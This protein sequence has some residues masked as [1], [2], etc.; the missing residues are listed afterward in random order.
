MTENKRLITFI[1]PAYNEENNIRRF[2]EETN[3]TLRGLNNYTCD[4]IFIDDVL[5]ALKKA[6]NVPKIEGEIFNI[7]SGIGYSLN[8]IVNKIEIAMCKKIK[9][10]FEKKREVD[11]SI[12][13][14]DISKSNAII[15]NKSLID[16]D[17]GLDKFLSFIKSSL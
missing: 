17:Q 16:I 2:H 4:F 12:S 11:I 8:Q 3:K 15:N 7:G 1:I 10:R 14:L 13:I 5:N 6:A 9:C